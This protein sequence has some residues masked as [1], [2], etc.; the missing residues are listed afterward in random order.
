MRLLPNYFG[1]LFVVHAG[2]ARKTCTANGTWYT[3]NSLE[4]T[5]YRDCLDKQ[6][7][8]TPAVAVMPPNACRKVFAIGRH[9][10]VTITYS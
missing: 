3:K 6:V 1:D 2:V 5:D 4:W 9:A 8:R 7:T 10:T